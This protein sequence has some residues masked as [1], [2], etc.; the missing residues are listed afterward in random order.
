MENKT[1]T[2]HIHLPE[3][4]E[5]IGQPIVL[6]DIKELGFWENPVVKLFQ[7]FPKNPTYWHSE[8]II[9]SVSNIPEKNYI[10]Y[11]FAIHIPKP[12]FHEK[13]VFEGNSDE[14]N[15]IL[16]I[17][18]ENQF[19]I[20]KNNFNLSQKLS[21][22]QIQDYAFV[23]YIFNS[24]EIHNFK[25]KVME[26]QHLL[27]FHN[28][29]TVC[30]SNFEYIVNNIDD[31]L[32]EKRLFLCLLL[33]YHILRQDLNYELP[34]SFSS[35]LL[36]DALDNYKQEIFPSDVK[37]LFYTAITNLIQHNAFQYQFHWLKIF[38]LMATIDP[39]YNF[40]YHLNTLKYPND[41]LLEKF[42]KEV[43]IISPHI[44]NID[45]NIYVKI[46]KWLI[47]LCHNNDSLFKLWNDIL[48]HNNEIDKNIF[49]CFIDQVQK[50]ISNGDS[51]ALENDFN[52]I[53]KN[54]HDDVTEV[55]RNHILFLLENPIRKWENRDI[56]AIRKLLQNDGLNWS[57]DDAIISLEYI[58]QSRSLELLNIFPEILDN[59]FRNNFSDTKKKRLPS[60]C[61]NWFTLLMF[62]LSANE[63]N[64]SNEVN[65]I[66]LIFQL[67]ERMHPLLSHRKNIWQ[68]L[69]T[70]VVKKV[71]SR[72]ESQIIDAIKL[73]GQIKEQEIKELFSDII[74]EVIFIKT[75]QQINDRL[76]GKIF[77][78]CGCKG[79]KI[80]KVPNI[81]IEDILCYILDELQRK[82]NVSD[83]SEQYINIIKSSKFLILI[84]NSTGSVERLNANSYLQHI[85]MSIVEL[86][87]LLIEET[88]NLQLL[89]Q[90]LKYSDEQLFQ[91]FDEI[92]GKKSL[93]HLIIS[94][95]E[96]AKLR[97]LYHDYELKLDQ[98]LKFYNN[99]C[100]ESKVM[101][102]NNFI[103]DIKKRM[104]NLDKVILNKSILSDHWKLHE[105]T[106]D[107]AKRCY[108]FG[109][110]QIFN[111]I[112]EVYLRED[113]AAIN[114]EYIAQILTP[115]V[116]KKYDA[117][118][119]EWEKFKCSDASLK[120][121]TN[122]DVEIELIEYSSSS[123][124]QKFAQALKNLSK[125][126]QWI[127]RFEHLKKVVKIF[128]VPHNEDNWLSK[129]IRI[130]KDDSVTLRVL[131]NFFDYLDKN[132]SV[133][134]GCW[135]LIK[136]LSIAKDLMVFLQII[137]KF[138]TRKLLNYVNSVDKHLDIQED[139]I[140]SL[141]QVEQF[142]FPLMNKDKV[143]NI[144]E[145]LKELQD[146]IIKNS[147]LGGKVALC[148]NYS[149]T[150]RMTYNTILKRGEITKENIKNIVLNGIYIF[151]RDERKDKCI[152]SL[153]YSSN[154]MYNLNEILDLRV[155][156]LSIAKKD[157]DST[158]ID[159][160]LNDYDTVMDDFIFQVDVAQEI[161]VAVSVLIQLGHFHF[162]N[163]NFEKKLQGTNNMED[164]LKFLNN[165]LEKWKDIVDR[166]RE[167][168]YYLTFF[169]VRHILT[170]YDYFTSEK[171]DKKNEEECKTLIRFVN[172]KDQLPS[173]NEVVL[174]GSKDDP[175]TLNKIG[176][177]L[178]RIFEDS[179]KQMRKFNVTGQRV[180][181]DIVTKSKLFVAACTDSSR[182]PN[183]IM[184]L[185]ANHGYYP[186]PWQLL[187]C[188]SLTTMEEL[189]IFI[190]RSFFASN[191]G[192][193]NYLFCIANLELLDFELQYNLVNQI[194]AM[195]KLHDQEIDYL[196]ALICYKKT[197]MHHY[198][199]DQFSR[200]VHETNGLSTET[201]REV[202][203]KL[204]QSVIRVS[205]DLSG[206]GKTEW[207]KEA[208]FAKKKIL[209][210][211]LISDGMGF[212][213]LVTRFKECKLQQTES[214]HIN[215]VSTDHPED[216]NMFLFELLTLGMVSTNDIAYLPSLETPTYVFIEIAST[217]EQRLLNSLPMAG[218]ILFN[219]LTWNIKNLS[220]SQEINS[221]IQIV[222][223][224]LSLL[225]CNKIDIKEVHFRTNE[226]TK[227]PLSVE[228]CQSL[229]DK[230]IFNNNIKVVSSFRFFEIFINVLTDQLVR[231]SS[232][233]HFTL[234]NLG[235]LKL[236]V[237]E[238]N[239]ALILRIL[240]GISKDF[241][242]RSIKTRA[243]ELESIAADGRNFVQWDNFN[244]FILFF[245]SQ[246]Q[247]TITLL[248]SDRTKAYD[249]AKLLL[250]SDHSNWK[251]DD[252]VTMS[253]NEI[254]MKLERMVRRSTQKLSL[255]EYVLSSDN[256]IKMAL[257]LLRVRSNVPVVI[258]GEAGCGKTSLIAY[259]AIMI[260]V[261]FQTLNLHAGIDE[262]TFMLFIN[263]AMKKAG[264]GEIW[265]LFNGINTC[266]QIEL[267]ADL[268][269][270]RM[271][272]GKY[273]HPNIRLFSTCNP[274]RL[275]TGAQSK[276]IDL[277]TKVKK[278]EEKSN[279]VYQVT[280]LPDQ[281]LDYVFDYGILNSK[282]E[283]KYIQIMVEKELKKLSHPVFVE[284][285]SASQ[286][287]IR[288]VEEPYSVSLRDVKRA[289]TL[290]EF[291][292]NSL[293]KRQAYKRGHTH[294]PSENP[295]ITTRSYV[296]ALSFCYYFR[297]YEQDLRKQYHHD[298]G[299]ILQTHN[300]DLGEDVFAEI[301]RE[302]Q[303]YYINRMEI[304][305]NV[306]I[307]EALSENILVMI[308]C[309]LTRI[310]LFLIGT[311]G[312]SKSL[313]INLISSNLNGFNSRDEYFR[314]LPQIYLITHQGSLSSTADDIIKVFG[315]AKKYQE[316]DSKEFPIISVV[317]LN[318]VGLDGMSPSNPLS[319]LHSL[320][321]PNYPD[322]ELTVAVIGISNWRPDNS[323]ISR[324]ILVQRPQL[325]LNDLV[326]TTVHL[327]NTEL[328]DQSDTLEL[329]SKAYLDYEKCGQI[330]PNFHGL[331]D[332]YALVKQLSLDEMTP[333][334]IQTALAR[335]FGG[336]ENN[337]KL[338]EKH[339]GNVLKMYN[340]HEPWVY[341]PIPIEKLINLDL[342]DPDARHLMVIGRN[343]TIVNLLTRQLKL[344]NLDPVVIL[345]SQFSSDRDDYLYNVLSKI[346]ICIEE[347]RLLIL[348][349]LE[350]IYERL[351][352]LWNR[353][354]IVIGSKENAKYFIRVEL[355]A[356]TNLIYVSPN[357]KCIL[358]MDEKNLS[359]VEPSFLSR[360]EKQKMSINDMLND[361]QKSLVE[362]LKD[363]TK[364]MTTYV[365]ANPVTKLLNKFTQKDLFIGFDKDETLQSLVIDTTK[366]NPEAENNE[367]LENCK[368][369]LVAIASSD[370][371]IRAEQSVLE[372]DEA[373]RWKHVYY[374]KQ[375][376]DS[377]Y[378]Y[379]YTLFNQERLLTDSESHLVIVNTF[380]SINTDVK[381][382]LQGL[383]KC[384]VDTLSA[385]KTEVQFS[386]WVKHF[387]LKS[388]DNMLILQCDVTTVNAG[389][390]KLAKFIIEQF[391]NEYI[392]KE[393]HTKQEKHACII[394]H[395]HRNQSLTLSFNF[396][397]GWKQIT[398]ETL[399][400]N[401]RNDTNL[402]NKSLYDIIT[403]TYPFEEILQEELLWCLSCMKYPSNDISANHVKIL[404]EKIL[405]CS[406]FIK[407]LKERTLEWIEEKSRNDRAYKVVL[408]DRSYTS[409][410]LACQVHIRTL[411]RKPI[412][413][414]LCTLERMSAT[415]TIFY[416]E[417]D[418][419]LF[420]FW[421]QIFMNKKIVKIEDLSDPNPNEYIM[422]SESLYDL[423]F[424]FSLYFMKQIDTFKRYYEE[425]IALLQQD[426]DRVDSAI[427]ELYDWVI[428][429]HLK[430]FKNNI[431]S[432][433]PQLRD[434]P[435]ERF[436][437]LYFND[438]VTTIAANDGGSKNTKMLTTILKLLIGADKVYQPIFLHT[439]WWKN[440]TE[441]LA[442][443]QLALMAPTA[444][445]NI[446]IRGTGIIG[447]SFEKYLVKE[448]TKMMFQRIFGGA[449]NVHFIDRWQHDVIKVLSLG[450]KI[451]RAKNL[452]VF[453]FLRIVN[454][455]VASKSIPLDG[456]REIVQLGLSSDKQEILS[457][458]FVNTV[459]DKLGKLEQSEKNLI[460]RR[461]FI[462]RCLGLISIESDVRLSLY[463]RL[464]S[465]EPF[466]L[467]GVIIERIFLKEDVEQED[468]FFTLITNP[469]EALRRS[470]RLNIIN[471]CLNDLDTNMATLCCDVIEQAFFM[472]DEL[473]NL[474]PFFG[475]ALE[476][477]YVQGGPALQKIT[478]IAFLKEFVRR[479]WDSFIQEDKNR[480]IAYTQMEE[481][482]FDSGEVIDQINTYMNIAHPLVYS[483]KM[484]FLRD[485][486]QRDFSIDD[487]G[488]FCEAQKN[489]LPWLRT[490]NWEEIKGNRL[491]FN[492]YCNLPEYN[493]LEKG[494]M[495]FY[496]I[497]N[498]APF[499]EVIQN[500]KKKTTLT[501][502][503]SLFGLF[504]VRLHAIRAS[505]E[506][507]HPE[508]QSAEF[509]T[510]ELAG[511]NNFPVLFK[512]ITTKILSNRQPLLQINDSR[513][514]NT[515][516]ILK[517]VIAHIIAFHT[518]V[519]PNSSQLA[520]YLHRI[521]DCQ[522][523]FV[524][525]CTS[526]S[527]SVVLNAIAAAEGV[528]RYACKCGMKYVIANCG[529]AVT[530]G[531]CPNC[532]SIIG[533]TSHKPAAGNTRIDTEP[534]AQVPPNDQAGYI[535]EPV[536][537]TLTHSVRSLPPTSY[538]ILHLMV[539]ALIG[540]SA[541]QP[542]LAF[543]RKN[544]QTATNAERYC[545]D[546]IRNDWVILKNLLNCSDENLALMFH[547][548]IFSMTEKPPLPNQQI[549]SSADR[550]N[551]ETEF[552]RNYIAPQIRNIIETATNFRMK[553]NAALAKNQ[554]NNVIEGEINQTLVMDKQY[555]LENLPALWRTI[556]LVNFESFRAYYMSD[557][558][559]NRTN[560]PFLSIFFKYVGQLELLKH[561]LPIVKFVQV[562]NS[563]LG[564]QLTRQK[565]REMSFRQFIE[566][567]SDGCENR[568]TFNDLHSAF[569]DFCEGWNRVLPFV[570]RY[571]CYELPREK[572][573]M[574]Y[575]LP[576]VFGLMEQ[577]DAG[578]FLCAIL[579]FLVGLQN[580]FLEEVLSIPPGTCRSLEFLDEPTFNTKQT[581]SST[582]K[583]QSA[584]P[585]TPSGYYLQS[586][587]IDHARSANIIN[588]DWDDEILAY[589]QRNLAVAKGQD[590]I[591]DLTK[592]EAELASILVFEKV[593]IETQPESQLYLEPFP[594][595]ME[596][597]QGCMRILSDIKNL[598]TQEPIPADK[599]NL[600]SVSGISSS[601][602]FPQESTL[603]N[604]SEILSSLEFLL[605]FVKRTAVRDKDISIKDYISKWVKLSS[606]STHEGFARFLNIDL[607]L[608]HL[609]ALYE[610]VE[611]Q[612]A[613]VNIKYIHDKYKAPLS[614]EMKNAIIKSVDFEQQTTTKEIIPA[615]AFALALKRFMFRFLTLENQK[616]ME[617]LYVYLSDSSLS[618][619][620]ST[621]PEKL[622]DELF[623]ENLLVAN[624]YDVYDFTMR[625]LE[626]TFSLTTN[627][628]TR[629]TTN[630]VNRDTRRFR[631]DYM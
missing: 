42:I 209:R 440:A 358:V 83:A 147:S 135:G 386:N 435:L 468:V 227:K 176:D 234:N 122:V 326:S 528:T 21:L 314:T 411:V 531:T 465:N 133:S 335:N 329:L 494:F 131:N 138:D 140:S 200:D 441:V 507:R 607:R 401:A 594:Y 381:C 233:Q 169:S 624:T 107:S 163:K 604:A 476:A 73:I 427:N 415:K 388:T 72:P 63:K 608:K 395:I 349:N 424:P 58:S 157:T 167:R 95:D 341:K 203:R 360:F 16:D 113:D 292:Y 274:Y 257:I 236:I 458:N 523:L 41:D 389:C 530:T 59:F 161:I 220:V 282:D 438:F 88:I 535:G 215:I 253:E 464:F 127:E 605:C 346:L 96:I 508:K 291:F 65:F 410:S 32:K 361:R 207:I 237:E 92:I 467:M 56:F 443:L 247:D 390:I 165:E 325:N 238:A 129:S 82:S 629:L 189:M 249:N 592:I 439:Y 408:N 538:R 190:K 22:D 495:I 223:H 268:I 379:L 7:P 306:A 24:I 166:A 13:N 250:K 296:L 5:N 448:I 43:E 572:P 324:A 398:I 450:S 423:K 484:Y 590:I 153:K 151:V 18:K 10:Q 573:N 579:D 160:I 143:E 563:K 434:S 620:P 150:L 286:R 449:D 444:I 12:P 84:L 266:N 298:M 144:D 352:D 162:G 1:F 498:K 524:L 574:A 29:V 62:K 545:T 57:D 87:S 267:L 481:D 453:Q 31:K 85:Q 600:L 192:Y 421:R 347:G 262:K 246:D 334:N 616:E 377:L 584:K 39:K 158:S 80:L 142:L 333:E 551:W 534:I 404:S 242:A 472:N 543:L 414:I 446:E 172:S 496:S 74:K 164:Y 380:S 299:Q 272:N 105:K 219:H 420:K 81:M 307:N 397:C 582:S 433:I 279:L 202:Y 134:Q 278:Y 254:L 303:E 240:I 47:Q 393:D 576:V 554:K 363:W 536:N 344:K 197:G 89:Q 519:E 537:Q 463:K 622:I 288:K 159:D 486:R 400:R 40:I 104:Q 529:T 154:V 55:F 606:L 318:E 287:F 402:L 210:S 103:Q 97:K 558:A 177:E 502:K 569:D 256:L 141:I 106:L 417:N 174:C 182:I 403:C 618:F 412:A 567:Q 601:F 156:A 489:I 526:N 181:S 155:R 221:P 86:N 512:T 546:H 137:G 577:K 374:Y 118:C 304:P 20:W 580:K 285:L 426:E 585:N 2:F 99:H 504:Y 146:V 91:Y 229:I 568:E 211:F 560:Y 188:T 625:R 517:S 509:V 38:T 235:N 488:K 364:R 353:N 75:I 483:L 309:I 35:E 614:T 260:E 515:D 206:Q 208:S 94:R 556:G 179:P 53:P 241:A 121:I 193:N 619:W 119:K 226:A 432:S 611:E 231:L 471:K 547:S 191:N 293:E 261:Q 442:Q 34:T 406:K 217:V 599:M 152:V 460:S 368:E 565:A 396:M 382:C 125:R 392:A 173:R 362:G 370:G 369:C 431:F 596:L 45:F 79:S 492:P 609:V 204:C 477:M 566:N 627:Q 457:E 533:G 71:K 525:T 259:L 623:P 456:I 514:N 60:I 570:K 355:G 277:T 399:S 30:A 506:W 578:I 271:L 478:S 587:R 305:S 493:E 452:P 522:N 332:Y 485:L 610:F 407:C 597:F 501:A 216:V 112:F 357:F 562:L 559:K 114:V 230:Y 503:L 312:S 28:D 631:F 615:E 199:L 384:Q 459:L 269:S 8:P 136:E 548:L 50:N 77:T 419:E 175:E 252:Y 70:I 300:F 46:A 187:I 69:T 109:Q 436:P 317:L 351:Y 19:A 316:T 588:F 591:Y 101:G 281:I 93:G 491:T 178:K 490:L 302:E 429:D 205:S 124:N 44:K 462:M 612:V 422:A 258:C 470:A 387:W 48:A 555:R 117:L 542:A 617:S 598:I 130:L 17:E 626:Q 376:H 52:R 26:Y 455:L 289:I 589:S 550:E 110:S 571:Q 549:K 315:K 557:L 482:D 263:D 430:N 185:Y 265:L 581:V 451:T 394:L 90:L 320:L 343:D 255:P 301:I 553:L 195:Q 510:K 500:I 11:R 564:Y 36:L 586:M 51:V 27:D 621:V 539:H 283:L 98:L 391:R 405:K 54:C 183:V 201:M 385:F 367:I 311:P 100:S 186:E 280:P 297:L 264:K 480:P 64:I 212:D 328:G 348:A 520:M 428:E 469:A 350:T 116:F 575:K 409:F 9:I 630:S 232:N 294:P 593:H 540:A 521:Q 583:I 225:D 170:L 180:M 518:S 3:G 228:R 416:I 418:D 345:G 273:I 595:H 111:N 499:Q 23:D 295:T 196:L 243:T 115:A 327:L 383:V 378:D 425:E 33:G 171:L 323:K 76:I 149:M 337:V 61:T 290:V 497:G 37:V 366:N 251:L 473:K 284:L 527:E 239:I 340:N 375:N 372:R 475:H 14:D 613:N 184:S 194:R 511:M 132:H 373:D 270:R 513:I 338:Y 359:S 139:T 224:Y 445:Q 68:N 544:N 128:K 505:R 244:N 552:H 319:V 447:S 561:L 365:G 102:V 4:I 437:E 198:I 49:K 213:K 15:R 120:N 474:E 276:A 336:I 342:E 322:T 108:K 516:L 78:I 487:V 331:H 148:N 371:I 25:D 145:L 245:N 602:M 222:C 310:P 541:P 354:Y 454:D 330:S 214:M 67:L 479:F 123:K 6:G 275:R 356:Y 248:Y 66:S 218:Y 321:E 628:R 313:A 413:Q 466:S 308:V 168:C 461:S 532:K 339:F 126:P 603:D